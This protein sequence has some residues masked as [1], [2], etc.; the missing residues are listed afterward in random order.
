MKEFVGLLEVIL[1]LD[2]PAGLIEKSRN[3]ILDT[4][5]FLFTAL[6]ISPQV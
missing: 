4:G 6:V 3:S 5:S 1:H 2:A